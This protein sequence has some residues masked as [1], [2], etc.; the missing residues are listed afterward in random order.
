[1]LITK[2]DNL[3]TLYDELNVLVHPVL[4]G[5]MEPEHWCLTMQY[6]RGIPITTCIQYL[7]VEHKIE[8]SESAMAN[9]H[10]NKDFTADDG[11]AIEVQP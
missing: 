7:Q 5:N 2:S 4:Q 1:M 6:D 10:N 3:N 11:N 9:P 8:V